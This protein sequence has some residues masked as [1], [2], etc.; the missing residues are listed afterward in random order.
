MWHALTD[1]LR[2]MQQCVAPLSSLFF[3]H[4]S[5]RPLPLPAPV[6]QRY[7]S[8]LLEKKSR[9]KQTTGCKKWAVVVGGEKIKF[10]FLLGMQ[11]ESNG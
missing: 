11:L 6:Q 10:F 1:F 8:S 4:L 5:L 7:T 9:P 2:F 3:L